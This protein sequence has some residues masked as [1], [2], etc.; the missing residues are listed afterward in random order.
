M[1]EICFISDPDGMRNYDLYIC[2]LSCT[3]YD[4]TLTMKDK[5]TL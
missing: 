5:I 4:K 2:H 3:P 1:I